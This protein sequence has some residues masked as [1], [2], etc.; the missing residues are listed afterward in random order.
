[1]DKPVHKALGKYSSINNAL[2]NPLISIIT[3]T[4]N[5]KSKLER[6]VQ[7]VLSQS[8]TN[9]EFL[10]I[11][12]K[13]QDGTQE[14]LAEIS[15]PRVKYISE[16]DDGVYDAMNKGIRHVQGKYLYFLG[17][18]D[19][20]LPDALLEISNYLN[21]EIFS[22]IYGN[23][24]WGNGEIYD[25][26]YFK[27]KLCLRNICHQAIFYKRNVFEILGVFDLKYKLYADWVLNIRCFGNSDL[28]TCYAP[29]T[30]AM[31]EAGGISEEGDPNFQ[32]DKKFLIKQNFG[33]EI[34]RIFEEIDNTIKDKDKI[35]SDY[36]NISN[37]IKSI[38]WSLYNLFENLLVRL[39][40]K[41]R[42]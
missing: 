2:E 6:T 13:S 26:E 10:L 32:L 24:L 42:H 41:I 16:A 28:K 15:D 23:V 14:W 21:K 17:A 5:C 19:E 8:Y 31:Y 7:S 38:K 1:M 4:F 20:L 37:K 27:L 18:G 40:R 11:D 39:M 30:V 34:F 9:F 12:G 33:E 35:S 36:N 3:P 29:I 25:G 22:I